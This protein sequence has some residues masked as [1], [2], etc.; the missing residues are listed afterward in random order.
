MIKVA[1]I[2]TQ[3]VPAQ[4]GGFETLVENL[5]GKHSSD[6]VEYTVVCSSKDLQADI[7]VYK[8]AR[9]LYVPLHAN[10]IQSIPYDI[11][12]MC[13]V[14]KGYDVVLILGV[15]G[16]IFL[17]FFK[18]FSKSRIIVN[19]DGL[20]HKRDKW[21][22]FARW[23][24][25]S[26]EKIAVRYA[27]VV[28]SDN[29]GIQNYVTE[30]YG[31][32]SALIAYGGDHVIRDVPESEQGEILQKYGL[33]QDSYAMTVCRIEP[34]NNCHIIL[35]AFVESDK[36]L[37]FIGNWSK[38]EY[39]RSMKSKYSGFANIKLFDAI[40]DL[41]I[42]FT[43]RHNCFAYIHGHSAGGTNPSLV[44][45]MFFGKPIIAYNVIY[46]KAT[47]FDKASYFSSSIDL[48]A[49]LSSGTLC[50]GKELQHLAYGNYKW[51]Q[52]VLQYEK[53]YL[54]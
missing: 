12:S 5:I 13:K 26:S 3:G 43:L 21:G 31:K 30:I 27:D 36:T 1:I 52:I 2:G 38:S 11:V 41:N 42:L 50:N 8:K 32:S 53:L 23:F 34:E 28:V 18:M 45:A 15:S 24:L 9:L 33:Y 22:S 54:K 46:N 49:I 6:A 25:R 40:Y 48:R 47:T 37:V 16:C 29:K 7:S 20:E 14:M 51:E 39:G 10:G 4:Y 17:P 44:E 35:E 19:I